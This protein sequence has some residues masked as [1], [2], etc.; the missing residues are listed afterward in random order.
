MATPARRP[1]AAE[2]ISERL[3]SLIL[4]GALRPGEKLAPERDLA[5]KLNV[6]RPTLRDS[7]A[8]LA[9][10]GLLKTTR[11]GTVVTEF[12]T[13]FISPLASLLA[14]KPEVS[15]DYF[16][17]R[18]CIEPEASAHAAK[19]A[20]DLDHQV[21]K[22]SIDRMSQAHAKGDSIEEAEADVEF[23]MAI[24]EA[25]HNVIM[26]HI[27]R[28][29]SELMR[30]DVF[31]NRHQLYARSGVRRLLLAQHVAIADAVLA[32]NPESAYT[33][34]ADHV[35]FT[36]DTIFEIRR[37]DERMEASLDRVGRQDFLSV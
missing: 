20:T 35:R 22:R 34:A 29:M 8:R 28:A 4:S 36:Y 14:G 37:A 31:Y 9:D 7:I 12:L 25:S 21:I 5:E 10:K 19:R 24:Y 23:H 3:E 1:N 33:A 16:E 2:A 15:D 17:F 26:L 11:N 27:M 30:H 18:R 13:P 32:A 6:S